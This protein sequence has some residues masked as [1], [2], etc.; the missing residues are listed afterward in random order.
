M[1]KRKQRVRIHLA[2]QHPA[3]PL[4]SVEGLLV[5]KTGRELVIAI[6]ALVHSSE[7]APVELASRYLVIP[8]ERV[9][10]WEVLA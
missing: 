7:A 3:V 10:F 5:S 2:D 1:F 9:A 4:P 6:P 8:R